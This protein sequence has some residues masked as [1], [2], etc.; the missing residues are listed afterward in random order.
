MSELELR[1]ES[2]PADAKH[3]VKLSLYREKNPKGPPVLLLHGASASSQTFERPGP[4]PDGRSRSLVGH[5]LEEGFEPW[6]LDWRGSGRVV[7]EAVRSG[8]L[9]D[10]REQLDFDHAAHLGHP[11][12]LGADRESPGR[13][14]GHSRRSVTA[15]GRGCCAQ[16]IA[17]GFVSPSLRLKRVVLLTLGLFYEPPFD[18][19]LK[20]QD[21]ALDQLLAVRPQGAVGRSPGPARA[22][23]S[24]LEEMYCN[25]PTSLRPHQESELPGVHEMCNRL[26]FMYGTP[27]LEHQLVP[28]IHDPTCTI[29]FASGRHEPKVGD[30]LEGGTSGAA[31]ILREVRLTSGSW[32]TGD[33]K[34]ALVLKGT[35]GASSR[36]TS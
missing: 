32:K 19:R 29:S 25:W 1:F 26:S 5:L 24:A 33:A 13:C 21:H 17:G 14:E 6:L 28:E 20:T 3:R 10:L 7:D 30:S 2:G 15:W 22:G 11:P 27:Y 36:A 31:G 16:A 35:R 4:G 18:S 9:N 34:G 23:P 12:G 8:T